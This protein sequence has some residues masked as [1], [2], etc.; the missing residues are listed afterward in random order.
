MVEVTPVGH[1]VVAAGGHERKTVLDAVHGEAPGV[2]VVR[3]MQIG[4]ITRWQEAAGPDVEL[5]REL[6]AADGV[7]HL[8]VVVA[9][10][11][12]VQR[13]LDGLGDRTADIQSGA[14]EREIVD[15]LVSAI[16]VG[17]GEAAAQARADRNRRK[18][19][20]RCIRRWQRRHHHRRERGQAD[21]GGQMAGAT[22][23][24]IHFPNPHVLKCIEAARAPFGLLPTRVRVFSSRSA[25]HR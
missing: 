3:T 9:I 1:A 22:S 15:V 6:E 7:D 16:H 14:V 20:G 23:Q 11:F 19:H 24:L 8:H 5:R 2:A 21:T 17:A 4:A 10:D 25:A 13:E 18:L 12:G